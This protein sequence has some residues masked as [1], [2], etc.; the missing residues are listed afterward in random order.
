MLGLDLAEYALF[1]PAFLT[2][3]AFAI[4][5]P[6]LGCYLRL[7]DETLA[8]LAFA[9]V[10]ASGALGAMALEVSLHSGGLSA[11]LVAAGLK[12]T[13]PSGGAQAN[14]RSTWYALMLVLA[15]GV[16]ILLT[17]NLPM[18]ERLGHALFDGQLLLSGGDQPWLA[19]LVC[20]GGLLALQLLSRRLL[21]AQ[22]FPDI[23]RLRSP[24][25]RGLHLLFDVLAAISIA[26]ATMRLGVMAVFALLLIT[27]WS[28]FV[29]APNWRAGR[30]LASWLAVT[31][32]ITAFG[33]ALVWDQPFGPVLALT[34]LT[35]VGLLSLQR[36][37]R[38]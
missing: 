16:G 11:A 18:A 29:R 36:P 17:S 26:L 4:Y 38:N 22:I 21:L 7:R 9:Q 10:G 32:Y 1:L 27:P 3:L 31:A 8:A 30:W 2:G 20:G 23:W 12:Q 5:L 13:V 14:Q 37:I 19:A 33:L 15:W 28:A 24:H 34:L 25:W 6:V 35:V